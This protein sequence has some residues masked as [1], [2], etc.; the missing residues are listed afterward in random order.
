MQ[1]SRFAAKALDRG[2]K[3]ILKLDFLPGLT[4]EELTELLLLRRSQNPN[5]NLEE[6]M[7]GL[8]NHKLS[9]IM[10]KEAGL[11]V[12]RNVRKLTS[13]E[14][15][16][17]IT[18]M[19]ELKLPITATNS[20]ENAQVTAG[21]VATAEINENSLESKLRKNLYLVGELLDVDGTCGGYNLQWAWS[22]GYLAG[23]AAGKVKGQ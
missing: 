2:E 9:Y 17:L 10:I 19:K 12:S 8:F 18:N 4:R 3:V 13:D 22:T 6:M 14:L 11:D 7:V 21:G 23:T 15:K 1:L 16:P 5:K 20:F